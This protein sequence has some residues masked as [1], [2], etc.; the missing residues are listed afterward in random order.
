MSGPVDTVIDSACDLALAFADLVEAVLE[1]LAAAV[2][3]AL[4]VASFDASTESA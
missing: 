2:N 3:F 4:T 1:L